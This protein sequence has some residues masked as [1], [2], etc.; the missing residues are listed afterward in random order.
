M[1]D[2]TAVVPSSAP[3]WNRTPQEIVC[4]LCEYSLRGLSEPRCPE[5]GYRFDWAELLESQ[6]SNHPYLFEQQTTD[7]I[8]AFWM[9][10]IG[11]LSPAKFWR[12][13][14][15]FQRSH[16]RRLWRYFNIIMLI[17]LA[18]EAL[19]VL[20]F[21]G[22]S[23]YFEADLTRY[24]SVSISVGNFNLLCVS[25]TLLWPLASVAAF[26][27]FRLSMRQKKLLPIH[28]LRCVFYSADI[29]LWIGLVLLFWG[30][31]NALC[32]VRHVSPW[33]GVYPWLP[34][35]LLSALPVFFYRLCCAFRFYLRVDQPV[36]T[37]LATQFI[38]LLAAF[39]VVC[40]VVLRPWR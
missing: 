16:P 4:P 11:G 7:R 8:D 3:D 38:V 19:V 1:T 33:I 13:L 39:T 21:S 23:G 34:L 28:A 5:C 22:A 24:L 36:L 32:T 29:L 27:I 30:T 15:P 12:T 25:L 14:K 37:V 18:G 31:I 2:T 26:M 6:L 40:Y 17:V 9:T 10:C 35:L 20:G